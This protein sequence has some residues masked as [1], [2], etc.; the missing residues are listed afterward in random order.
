MV[1][2]TDHDGTNQRRG[3]YDAITPAHMPQMARY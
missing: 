3:W 1:L 2:R